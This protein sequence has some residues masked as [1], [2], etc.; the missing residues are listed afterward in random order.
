MIR[1]IFFFFFFGVEF[2]QAFWDIED[3]QVKAI[4]LF[5]SSVR[6]KSGKALFYQYI[7]S[8]LSL[9]FEVTIFF[10]LPV[11]IINENKIV[12]FL[13]H[14][15]GTYWNRPLVD[16]IVLVLVLYVLLLNSRSVL[17]D[18]KNGHW[19]KPKLSDISIGD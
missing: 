19:K 9:H 18:K 4:Q 15:F 5:A 2:M 12:L 3:V 13:F 1:R 6:D 16:V 8:A 10:C 14:I 17:L 7:Y 11:M